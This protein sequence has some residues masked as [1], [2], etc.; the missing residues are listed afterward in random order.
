MFHF[1]WNGVLPSSVS[2][3]GKPSQILTNVLE[4][5]ICCHRV[6]RLS[7]FFVIPPLTGRYLISENV[8]N[9]ERTLRCNPMNR[10]STSWFNIWLTWV[11]STTFHH[12]ITLLYLPIDHMTLH[13]L[14]WDHD[15]LSLNG[16]IPGFST[17][18]TWE[19]QQ[20]HTS[21]NDHNHGAGT[22]WC[23]PRILSTTGKIQVQN[24]IDNPWRNNNSYVWHSVSE[25]L[26]LYCSCRTFTQSLGVTH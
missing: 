11:C 19:D 5:W 22:R 15:K 9:S 21:D 13:M 14:P 25:F 8:Y 23:L 3:Y 20:W 17:G 2:Q 24:N 7:T 16:L 18:P 26:H 4:P 1:L 6:M 12:C 10:Y